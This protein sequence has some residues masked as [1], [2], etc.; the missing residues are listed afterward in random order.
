MLS[1]EHTGGDRA[2]VCCG[3]VGFFDSGAGTLIESA[4]LVARCSD[5]PTAVSE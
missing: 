2:K 3:M 4:E 1:T 5:V